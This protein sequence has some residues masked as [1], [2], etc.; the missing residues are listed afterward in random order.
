MTAHLP[1]RRKPMA[2]NETISEEMSKIMLDVL[3]RTKY[4][5]EQMC[6]DEGMTDT[7][8]LMLVAYKSD[9]EDAVE[10]QEEN[11]LSS[12]Y[13]IAMIPLIHREDVLEAYEDVVKAMPIREFSFLFLCVEGFCRS[14]DTSEEIDFERGEMQKDFSENPFSEVRE[15]IV[16][17]GMDWDGSLIGSATQ[18]YRYDDFGVPVYSE[19][20]YMADVSEVKEGQEYGRMVEA[21]GA[22]T[23]YMKLAVVAHRYHDLLGNAKKKKDEE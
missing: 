14:A 23:A 6:K 12:P 9:D 1:T 3:D 13:K 10:Y 22:T 5:K 21:M 18:M 8:P 2:I 4:A 16:V 11:E 7:P 17:T 19:E 15:A 20:D